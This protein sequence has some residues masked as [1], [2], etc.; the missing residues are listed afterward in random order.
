[1]LRHKDD[2][3]ASTTVAGTGRAPDTG[4]MST[5]PPG[6][7][8]RATRRPGPPGGL[9]TAALGV[10]AALALLVGVLLLVRSWTTLDN[11][12]GYRDS[13]VSTYVLFAA[14]SG[15]PGLLLTGAGVVYLRAAF[16]R[17]DDAQ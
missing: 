5:P 2:T 16:V 14:L 12:W 13:A 15:V 9:T 6:R 11:I 7:P 1:M 17:R 10:M 8:T 4:P 3:V